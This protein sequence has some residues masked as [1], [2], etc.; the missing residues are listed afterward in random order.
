MKMKKII[1]PTMAM[2]IEKVKQ[3]L[4]NDAVIFHTKKVTT[5][6]FFNFLKKEQ[7]EVLAASDSETSAPLNKTRQ[8]SDELVKEP[9]QIDHPVNNADMPFRHVYEKVDRLVSPPHVIEE[10]QEQLLDQ[11]LA[12]QEVGFL[13]RNLV[14]KWFQSDEQM[15]RNE[16]M[17]VLREQLIQALD[18]ARFQGNMFSDKYVMLAGPT[19]VGK[20]TTLA[21]LA[22]R[23]VL[24]EGKKIAFITTDTYRIAAIDQLRMYADILSAPIETAYTARDFQELLKK[25]EHYDHVFIDTAGRNFQNGEYIN[26]LVHLIS[27]DKRIGIY[28]V[29]SATSKFEDMDSLIQQFESLHI[30]RLILSK[31]DETLSYGA[32]ISILL[33][34]RQYNVAYIT[35][36]QDVPDDLSVPNL[37]ELIN[38]LIGDINGKGSG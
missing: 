13:I 19:G 38:L 17:H 8:K 16:M 11:G 24:D 20:T 12:R 36:G 28:L 29:L 31:V 35:N 4:G 5:G 23:T 25:F 26:D 15:T 21:K 6:R 14:K 18:P 32:V 33:K 7:V 3:E 2:A 30:K 34:Y 10:I 37:R 22:G 27:Q 9:V 1:A